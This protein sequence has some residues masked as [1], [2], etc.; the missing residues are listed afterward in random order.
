MTA[1]VVLNSIAPVT[2]RSGQLTYSID[3]YGQLIGYRLSDPDNILTVTQLTGLNGS[4]ILG[5]D[6]R[7]RS[8]TLYAITDDY[9]LISINVQTGATTLLNTLAVTGT[10]FAM[11]FN[12]T[13]ANLRIVSNNNTSYFY[14]FT[15]NSLVP[16]PNVAYGVADTNFGLDANITAAGFTFND[17]NLGTG[18]TLFA[19]DS[20]N[21]VLATLNTATGILTT[22]GT[23]GL[24]IGADVSFDIVTVGVANA[25][26]VRSNG[27]LYTLDLTSGTLTAAGTPTPN[28]PQGVAMANGSLYSISGGNTLIAV[29]SATPSVTQSNVAISG[30]NGAV[31]VGLDQRI[32]TGVM[33][34]ITDDLRLLTLD[35]A[36]GGTMFVTNLALTG[37]AFAVDFNPTNNHLRVVSNNNTNYVYN[38]T[39][40]ALVLGSNVA[41]GAGDPLF[42]SDT[43]ITSAA[44]TN[45][46]N[47]AE[48]GTTLYV[49]D[50]RNNVLA[51][52]NAATGVL[53][54]VGALTLNGNAFD[55]GAE[56]SF[57]IVTAGIV[58]TAYLHNGGS[59][60]TVDLATG[61]LTLVYAPGPRL[62]H[63]AAST[64]SFTLPA[65]TFFDAD[66]DVL[67]LSATL[68]GGSALPAWLQFDAAT[69]Q[70]FGTPPAGSSTLQIYVT[71]TDPGGD[72]V[73][74][75]FQ[76]NIL[77]ENIGIFHQD[78]AGVDI[79]G[80]AFSQPFDFRTSALDDSIS[81]NGTF[82][83]VAGEVFDGG[84]G[85]DT[86]EFTGTGLL[87]Y[88]LRNDTITSIEALT[89]ADP[90]I[91][92]SR[93][94]LLNANQF[95][96]TGISSTTTVT[97]DGFA[98]TP[99]TIDIV[100]GTSTTL[101]LAGLTIAAVGVGNLASSR[102]VVIGDSD[103]ETI[104]GSSI[105]D[106]INGG[107][108]NDTL[109]GGSG[110]DELDGGAGMDT[111]SYASSSAYVIV[112]ISNN[113]ASGGDATGDVISNFEN[114][115]GSAFG[116]VLKAAA[117][118]NTILGGAGQDSI[119]IGNGLAGDFDVLDGG[120][121]RDLLDMSGL[122]NG[123]IW[124]DYGYNVIS[125]PNMASGFN[126][127]MAAGEARVV[128][129]DSMVGTS[130]GD[131]M[132]GDAGSNLIDGGAGNDILLSYSPYDTLTPYSSL[133]DV[134]L[135]GSGDDLLFSGTG[136]DYL[137]GGADNDTLEVGGGTDTV[138]TGLGNDTIF[139]S[140]RNGTD[141][142]TDFTGGAGVVDVLKLYGFGTSLD[143]YAEVF[144]VSSQ[145]GADTHIAL[146]DTTIILQNFTRATL[147]ADDFVFV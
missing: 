98:D 64:F 105:R 9:N 76:L 136:N 137:D 57:D 34:V 31:I 23:L 131:T 94:L 44:Y 39:T 28:P 99:D 16:G 27:I 47:D 133:G 109:N 61:A 108:G 91:N 70:F 6:Q 97:F 123:G 51:T 55:V 120:T 15:T 116:D 72:S 142:V 115:T 90:G 93:T 53:T 48:T 24:D 77:G 42:G 69:G 112:D 71:V 81:I 143:T 36:T 12:P 13:N 45:N 100:M 122:T 125:G 3:E 103:G 78:T 65:N 33:Y 41:Y 54:R 58:N 82:A 101:T 124:I 121:E 117:G 106:E 102:F 22:I 52:Q 66:G 95:D 126:L 145:Q 134:M 49:I 37:T 128:N 30:L 147:V 26:Y 19:I 138:V 59:L 68:A 89:L 110:A 127:S 96:G 80:P 83:D 11:D 2:T 67:T 8:E 60:Y 75:D 62:N 40:N 139:F 87:T 25:A 84:G 35:L 1:P 14:N 146:T 113:T 140:P 50:S 29:D 20:R 4:A 107:G 46:D 56:A 7:V 88:N 130:F 135:G 63:M 86:L 73:I 111:L 38:F 85:T 119:V 118:S 129:M 10:A 32:S 43:N 141:T 144:A 132:R 114:L 92:Q 74:T 104:I 17:N 5:L 79:F 21:D 18:T